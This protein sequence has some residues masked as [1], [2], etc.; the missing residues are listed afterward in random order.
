M[1]AGRRRWEREC[2]K[3]VCLSNILRCVSP[4]V[5]VIDVATRQGQVRLVEA[6]HVVMGSAPTSGLIQLAPLTILN[7]TLA[8][9]NTFQFTQ[10][11]SCF[12][13]RSTDF[14]ECLPTSPSALCVRQRFWDCAV[15]LPASPGN[16]LEMQILSSASNLLNRKL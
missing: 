1:N 9:G 8:S 5:A 4:R 13:I 11:P 3:F 14:L 7:D 15:I 2:G 10:R 6:Q 12:R 16:L